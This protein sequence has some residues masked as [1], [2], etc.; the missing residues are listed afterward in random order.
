MIRVKSDV[1]NNK[2]YIGLSN[3]QLRHEGAIRNALFDI[4]RRLKRSAKIRINN[5]GRTGKEYTIGGLVHRASS[6]GQPPA[7][8]TGKLAR[9]IDYNVRGTREVEYGYQELYGKFLEK[10]TKHMDIRPN[11]KTVADDNAQTFINFL[12]AHM[13]ESRAK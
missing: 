9:S 11:L 2:V 1:S 10:G 13:K 5:V 6:P 12:V 8:I 7:R 3:S 4:G